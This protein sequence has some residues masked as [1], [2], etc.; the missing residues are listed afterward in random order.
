M[1]EIDTSNLDMG[2]IARRTARGL[3]DIKAVS[4][5]ADEPFTHASGKKAP[6][7][8]DCR[9]IISFPGVRAQMMDDLAAVIRAHYGD[10]LDGVAGGE[11]AGIPFAAFVAERL[12]CPMTYVRKKPKGYGKNARIEGQMSEG[13][14]IL[15]VE[16]LTTDGGSKLSFVEAI[17][18]AGA[19]CSAT[20]VVF[21]YD[22]LPGVRDTLRAEGI[23]L[24]NLCTWWD[25]LAEARA[26]GDFDGATLDAVEEFLNDPTGWQAAHP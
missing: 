12:G 1:S 4:F 26:G 19:R 25:V 5:N 15:L 16:D 22:I 8:V 3:L 14:E 9:R 21:F 13:D 17:R 11:T 24:L 2:A 18:T 6:T 23:D 10:R 7:Y 20:A